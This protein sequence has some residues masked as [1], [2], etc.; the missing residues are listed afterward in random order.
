MEKYTVY[1]YCKKSDHMILQLSYTLLNPEVAGKYARLRKQVDDYVYEKC[2]KELK[3]THP[4]KMIQAIQTH[5]KG[6]WF[7]SRLEAR[8]AVF[9]D[10][11]GIE[12]TYEL[13]GYKLP[14]GCYLPDFYLKKFHIFYIIYP[15]NQGHLLYL[16]YCIKVKLLSRF[17]YDSGNKKQKGQ[18]VA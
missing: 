7:R 16:Y 4:L 17:H 6:Y 3:K 12:W 1:G 9:M 11:L 8:Y 2:G 15:Y 13:E 18:L 14:S 5:Y 10:W